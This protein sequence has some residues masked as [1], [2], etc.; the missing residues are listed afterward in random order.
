MCLSRTVTDT[1][2]RKEK[3]N[4]YQ[5][6]I[7]GQYSR[8]AEL[9]YSVTLRITLDGDVQPSGKGE[10]NTMIFFPTKVAVLGM[11]PIIGIKRNS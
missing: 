6:H 11:R 2:V 7:L 8:K 3:I 9:F 10:S 5:N 4:L 1:C